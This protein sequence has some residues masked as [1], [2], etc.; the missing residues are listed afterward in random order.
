M[1]WFDEWFYSKARWAWQRGGREN[2]DWKR[3]EDLLDELSDDDT[4]ERLIASSESIGSDPHDLYDGMRIDVKR[5]NGGYVVSFRHPPSNTKS[6][7]VEEVKRN[8]YIIREDEDFNATLGKLLTM[9][10]LK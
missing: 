3:R 5:L 6:N 2:P 7:Y 4:P 10:L 8:S 1:K 9:E